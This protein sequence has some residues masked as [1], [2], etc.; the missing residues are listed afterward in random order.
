MM[1]EL[2]DDSAGHLLKEYSN[3]FEVWLGKVNIAS[4][5]D[6]SFKGWFMQTLFLKPLHLH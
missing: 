3:H 5:V 4:V 6:K 1:F 2:K